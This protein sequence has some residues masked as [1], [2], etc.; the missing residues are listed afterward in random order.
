MPPLHESRMFLR[1]VALLGMLG[2]PLLMFAAYRWYR[3]DPTPD[4]VFAGPLSRVTFWPAIV[5][6]TVGVVLAV[7]RHRKERR[8]SAR[9]PHRSR[10]RS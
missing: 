7:V 9:R 3:G 1:A 2:V 4:P 10:P 8:D 5:L 6:V